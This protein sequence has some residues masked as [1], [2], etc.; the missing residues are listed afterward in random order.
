MKQPSSVIEPTTLPT[1][2]HVFLFDA[3]FLTVDASRILG[4]LKRF[5]FSN[6]RIIVSD[7]C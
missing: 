6:L 3:K 4:M 7:G 5:A 1:S 2:V